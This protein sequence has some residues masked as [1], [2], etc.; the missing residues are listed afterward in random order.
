MSNEKMTTATRLALIEQA[1]SNVDGKLDTILL[2]VQ[3]DGERVTKVEDTQLVC[4]A[5]GIAELPARVRRLED[6]VTEMKGV[7]RIAK[8]AVGGGLL[9]A[10]ALLAQLLTLVK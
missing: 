9:G 8:W 6:V 5:S 1:L 7:G 2:L 10:L 3:T 4:K